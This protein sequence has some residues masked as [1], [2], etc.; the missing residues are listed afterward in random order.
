[1][2]AI[3]LRLDKGINYAGILGYPFL[4]KSVFSIDYQRL[5][6]E[7]SGSAASGTAFKIPQAGLRVPFVLRDRLVH[8]SALVNGRGPV[9]FL[10]DTGSAEVLL[11]PRAAEL[12]RLPVSSAQR[13][14]GIRLTTLERITVGQVTV[15]NV[16]AI[17]HRLRREGE[18]ALSYDG[19]LGYPFLSQFKTTFNYQDNV[20]ILEP[21]PVSLQPER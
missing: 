11:M 3:S 10:V 15:T 1:L 8:I 18:G 6:L 7:W 12:L 2:Q 9:T 4:S 21:K 16:P 20:L 19:I 5:R 17:I 14:D 13:A